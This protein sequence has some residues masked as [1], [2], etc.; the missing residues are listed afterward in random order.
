VGNGEP[1]DHGVLVVMMMDS[2]NLMNEERERLEKNFVKFLEVYPEVFKKI[3]AHN[4]LRGR[5]ISWINLHNYCIAHS[6]YEQY[7]IHP[8]RTKGYFIFGDTKRVAECIIKDPIMFE[9]TLL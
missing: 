5:V 3:T 8:E 6:L 1:R 4:P 7:D 9:M 2:D